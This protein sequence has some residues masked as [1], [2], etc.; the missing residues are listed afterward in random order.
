MQRP[1]SRYSWIH[2]S[3]ALTQNRRVD[4][5]H[6]IWCLFVTGSVFTICCVAQR[7]LLRAQNIDPD[8]S[9]QRVPDSEL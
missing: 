8:D 7:G 1:D 4:N 3:Y 5:Y 9:K 6:M 2:C